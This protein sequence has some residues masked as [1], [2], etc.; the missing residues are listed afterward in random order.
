MRKFRNLIG[1]IL[2]RFYKLHI[3]VKYVLGI[4]KENRNDRSK[5][6]VEEDFI[7]D[8]LDLAVLAEAQWAEDR[9][10]GVGIPT[11]WELAGR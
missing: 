7:I 3:R 8:R 11:E 9:L 4:L 6:C 5:R 10:A 1:G 2:L